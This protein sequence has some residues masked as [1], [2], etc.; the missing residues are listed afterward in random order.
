MFGK[1]TLSVFLLYLKTMHCFTLGSSTSFGVFDP[2]ASTDPLTPGTFEL[3]TVPH[4]V[5][6]AANAFDEIS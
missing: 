3:L 2:T 4:G 1:E 6:V 5:G